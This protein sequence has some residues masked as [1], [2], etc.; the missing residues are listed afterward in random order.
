VVG[1]A[2]HVVEAATWDL[3]LPSG[4]LLAGR[5]LGWLDLG[6]A[7]GGWTVGPNFDESRY[8]SPGEGGMRDLLFLPHVANG[9]PEP[10]PVVT[11]EATP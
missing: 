4:D 11:P 7:F 6:A 2:P 8:H 5:V 9:E 3:A 1:T 10:S